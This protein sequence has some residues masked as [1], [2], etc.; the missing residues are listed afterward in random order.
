[1]TY[2]ECPHESSAF[3]LDAIG[4]LKLGSIVPRRNWSVLVCVLEE[5]RVFG[6]GRGWRLETRWDASRLVGNKRFG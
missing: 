5:K 3:F 6:D 4:R 1:M 2:G